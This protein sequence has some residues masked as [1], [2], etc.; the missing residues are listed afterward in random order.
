MNP[1]PIYMVLISDGVLLLYFCTCTPPVDWNIEIYS[2]R[3]ETIDHL[4]TKLYCIMDEVASLGS[5][6]TYI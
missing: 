1:A 4:H 2:I 3:T 5:F 6:Y